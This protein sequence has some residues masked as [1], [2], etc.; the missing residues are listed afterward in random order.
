M[1]KISGMIL[2]LTLLVGW[3]AMAQDSDDD[4]GSTFS[5]DEAVR[6]TNIQD[7]TIDECVDPCEDKPHSSWNGSK[8]E[9]DY[10]YTSDD[11]GDCVFSLGGEAAC[12]YRGWYWIDGKCLD[13]RD[14]TLEIID[15]VQNLEVYGA[16]MY[17]AERRH[18]AW[19]FE[20]RTCKCAN[21]FEPLTGGDNKPLEPLICDLPAD[22]DQAGCEAIDG[23]VWYEEYCMTVQRARDYKQSRFMV[24]NRERVVAAER[25]A[26]RAKETADKAVEDNRRQDG[27]IRLVD[28][29]VPYLLVGVGAW[30]LV[31]SYINEEEKEEAGV[32]YPAIRY[33][34]TNIFPV[35]EI[36]MMAA[37]GKNARG[38]L[39]VRGFVG[40]HT[41]L[42]VGGGVSLL[43]PIGQR[44]VFFGPRVDGAYVGSYVL[45][46][47]ADFGHAEVNVMSIRPGAEAIIP[48]GLDWLVLSHHQSVGFDG[49]WS[50]D[51][52]DGLGVSWQAGFTLRFQLGG[53]TLE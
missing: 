48:L 39:S 28:R 41:G 38:R 53:P 40:A 19:D 52:Y 47:D 18:T 26:D 6:A 51:E 44:G 15:A 4:N 24:E 27:E 13:P 34:R 25:T 30:G 31:G 43:G 9:C 46:Y 1:R 17:D 3:P 12:R 16:C 35:L 11:D 8:C 36:G 5:L 45:D 32:A 33:P 42:T 21:G 20:S 10:G 49:F 23:Y 14:L 2:I 37:T 50:F 7:G 29:K 22:I